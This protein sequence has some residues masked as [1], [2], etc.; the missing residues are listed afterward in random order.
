MI[1]RVEK[2][3]K[4]F[5][6]LW[7]LR[8]V[9]LEVEEGEIL[10]I[11]GPNGAGKTTLFNCITGYYKPDSG[12]IVFNSIDITGKPPYEVSRLGIARTF[13]LTKAFNSLTVFDNIR[14]AAMV[15]GGS[16]GDTSRVLE[17]T[18]LQDKR[19][20]LVSNLTLIERKRL[21]L[22]RALSIKPRL[23]LLD[24]VMAGLKPHE[25]DE[26]IKVVKDINNEGV[27]VIVVEH[28]IRT[29]MKLCRRVAVLDYGVKIAEGSPDEIARDERVIKAYLGEEFVA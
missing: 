4:R 27:T 13:Q 7:A 12:R 6:G 23:M 17:L 18:G 20:V 2:V 21:E 10:G 1:L 11:I 28:V 25:A 29:I 19:D 22:A 24:E 3:S 8:G 9:D 5:G 15:S 14:I 26:I 16:L